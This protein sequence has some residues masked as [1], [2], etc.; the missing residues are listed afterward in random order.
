[1]LN[2]LV[3][4]IQ[5]GLL[6]LVELLHDQLLRIDAVVHL[7]LELFNRCL[8]PVFVVFS[9]PHVF[10]LELFLDIAPNLTHLEVGVH[11]DHLQFLLLIGI[12]VVSGKAHSVENGEDNQSDVI[13]FNFF[14]NSIDK[15]GLCASLSQIFQIGRLRQTFLYQFRHQWLQSIDYHSLL[16]SYSV[17]F[18]LFAVQLDHQLGGIDHGLFA[19]PFQELFDGF[20]VFSEVGKTRKCHFSMHVIASLDELQQIEQTLCAQKSLL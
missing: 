14:S 3:E 11:L 12:E 9:R 20:G 1:M 7:L 2:H 6:V 16:V 8:H 18:I 19:V 13:L 10:L 17:F 5:L 15:I 4:L